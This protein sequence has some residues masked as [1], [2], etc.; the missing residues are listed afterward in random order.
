[1]LFITNHTPYLWGLWNSFSN[2]FIDFYSCNI[3][4]S[5]DT[6]KNEHKSP[7]YIASKM[8]LN[9]L[10]VSSCKVV[11]L[12]MKQNKK[13]NQLLTVHNRYW[14]SSLIISLYRCNFARILS[15]ASPNRMCKLKSQIEEKI[16][17][18]LATDCCKQL[19]YCLNKHVAFSSFFFIFLR[20][21]LTFYC[22]VK[23]D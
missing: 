11:T 22:T 3:V 21:W 4:S 20:L 10:Y 18:D 13:C 17:S 9:L 23:T 6:R 14:R 5:S 8:T 1:M 19:V 16:R 2:C 7:P 12:C 15:L